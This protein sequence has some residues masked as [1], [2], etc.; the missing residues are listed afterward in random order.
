MS[1]APIPVPISQLCITQVLTLCPPERSEKAPCVKTTAIVCIVIS[2]HLT[3]VSSGFTWLKSIQA[4]MQ[5]CTHS[6]L[7]VVAN[8]IDNEDI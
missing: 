7:T 8:L 4:A 5:Q 6:D 3:H 1:F 2:F